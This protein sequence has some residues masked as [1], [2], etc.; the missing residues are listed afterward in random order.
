MNQPPWKL[1]P[2]DFAFLWEECSRC[3]YLKYRR[4]I[5]RPFTPM[6]K[7]FNVIDDRMRQGLIDRTLSELSD[8]FPEGVVDVGEKWVE[9]APIRPSGREA[10][11]YIRGRFDTLIRLSDGSFGVVDFKTS[12]RKSEHIPLYTRQLH[13]YAHAL[14]NPSGPDQF[15]AEPIT[16]LG[17]LVFEPETF[18]VS[19]NHSASLEGSLGWI[20]VER[21]DERFM[22]FLS[23]V[24]DLLERPAPPPHD[25]EC[26]YCTYRDSSA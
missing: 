2:S 6:P 5:R 22:N 20:E 16:R 15:S 1:S 23:E 7:I 13:A 4:G 12:S 9:S 25:P 26:D 19:E 3:F 8:D 10:S 14:E 21:D 24:L 11:C 18:Q 17:L